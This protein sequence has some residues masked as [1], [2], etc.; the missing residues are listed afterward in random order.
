[1]SI[2]CL[3]ANSFTS[4]NAYHNNIGINTINELVADLHRHEDFIGVNRSSIL[5]TTASNVTVQLQNFNFGKTAIASVL[6]SIA[7]TLLALINVEVDGYIWCNE[8]ESEYSGP[9]TIEG[10]ITS[11]LWWV[12]IVNDI[13]GILQN[14]LC[15]CLIEDDD[16]IIIILPDGE[17]LI[18]RAGAD[19]GANDPD[20]AN[21]SASVGET[22][23]EA[24]AAF[25]SSPGNCS[26][27]LNFTLPPFIIPGSFYQR[28]WTTNIASE[29]FEDCSGEEGQ[30]LYRSGLSTSTQTMIWRNTETGTF[31]QPTDVPFEMISSSMTVLAEFLFFKSEGGIDHSITEIINNDLSIPA[32]ISV[33]I[34]IM[35]SGVISVH[36][37]LFFPEG[38]P[39]VPGQYD[40][41]KVTIG[42]W[43]DN[44]DINSFN[45]NGSDTARLNWNHSALQLMQPVG[46]ENSGIEYKGMII[47]GINFSVKARRPAV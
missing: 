8:D 21:I 22:N 33:G 45:Y 19:F 31:M 11:H 35:H 14:L 30:Y 41:G 24:H 2:N 15:I 38:P 12:S 43:G 37:P 3:S 4:L 32:T 1:M 42:H 23:E 29:I 17:D 16:D 46:R 36:D 7:N 40:G 25:R 9:S 44:M 6:S 20:T 39:T 13:R 28:Y 10:D 5:G 27:S 47:T 18:F 34:K 26:E